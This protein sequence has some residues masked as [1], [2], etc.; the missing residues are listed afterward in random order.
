MK[1]LRRATAEV[2]AVSRMVGGSLR[3]LPRFLGNSRKCGMLRQNTVEQLARVG[4][5]SVGIVVLVV[6]VVGAVISM[7]IGPLL[8]DYGVVIMI[9]DVAGI[10]FL[11]ELGPMLTAVVLSGYAG[12]SIAAELGTMKVGEEIDALRAM[13]IDPFLHLVVPRILACTVMTTCLTAIGDASGVLGGLAVGTFMMD[14]DPAAYLAELAWAT[15]LSDLI[16]GLAKAVMF[17]AIVGGIACRFGLAVRGGADA[18]G[19]AATRTIVW[20]IVTLIL[21]DLLFTIGFYAIR[22]G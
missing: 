21:A 12:A 4:G 11:R 2:G 19:R 17:G 6:F 22:V 13:A 7:Q 16:S 10:G 5:H 20:S 9:A 1:S 14:I 18:V 15:E 8:R 3:C